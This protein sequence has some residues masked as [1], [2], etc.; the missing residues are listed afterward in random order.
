MVKFASIVTALVFCLTI[1]GISLVGAAGLSEDSI[2]FVSSKDEH[3]D[4]DHGKD[5]G[6][7]HKKGHDD[8]HHDKDHHDD[9]HHDKG[10]KKS[11]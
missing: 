9:D 8:E 5:H 3:H 11:H 1:G 6:K 7:D 10:H 4:K 2:H